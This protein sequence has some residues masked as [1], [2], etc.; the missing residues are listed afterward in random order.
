MDKIVA[1]CGIN[2]Q[3]CPAYI[4]TVNDD[5][6]M[7]RKTAEQWSKQ[8]GA[9][10]KPEHINCMSC[11]SKEGPVFHHCTVCEIRKCGMEREVLNCARCDEYACE[12]LNKLLEMVP[13]ARKTLD[14]INQ[15]L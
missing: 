3:V 2:C 15:G 14:G 6:E 8:Y 9:D 11:L 10:I 1:V 4:A 13:D 5:D 7:R 12:K